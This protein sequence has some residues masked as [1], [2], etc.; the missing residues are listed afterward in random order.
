MRSVRVC[1]L[2]VTALA[3]TACSSVVG[4]QK[5][6]DS[7]GL[8]VYTSSGPEVTAPIVKAFEKAH[9]DIKVTLTA[10]SGT[11]P[12]MSRI[13]GEKANPLGDVAWGGSIENYK[14]VAG[15]GIWAP[16]ELGQDKHMVAT[17]PK[18]QWHA[19]DL[20]YQ[21]IAVNTDRVKNPADYPRTMKDL[22]DPKWKKEGGIGFAN[23][24]SSGTGYSVL[25]AMVSKYG[26][27]YVDRFLPNAK[28]TDSSDAM[29]KGVR[30]GEFPVA[31]I[32]ED[33]GN[34]WVKAKAPLK[35]VYPTDVVSN[36]IGAAAVIKDAPHTANAKTFVDYLMSAKGQQVM[37]DAVG[38]RSARTDLPAP[39][40]LAEGKSLHLAKSPE[41][42]VS[43]QPKVLDTFDAASGA[44]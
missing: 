10:I 27:D 15:K 11:G 16:A 7:K 34:A 3:L 39:A 26:W 29:F 17:D 9:P 8:V 1:V 5:S 28:V 21:A 19:T 12:L 35:L 32:N 33:L 30:N 13:Q 24:R 4:G 14:A 43:E 38:R 18:H 37:S 23:P 41:E 40:G 20:L 6:G 25:A 2:A 36:Q 22:A 42:F 44:K 31:F